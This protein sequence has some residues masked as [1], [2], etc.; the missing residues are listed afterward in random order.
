M[1]AVFQVGTSEQHSIEVLYSYWTGR[2]VVKVDG[3]VVLQK[4]IWFSDRV[5][6]E[7]GSLEKHQVELVCNTLTMTSQAYV[8]GRL[9]VGC[10]FPQVAGY[11]AMIL[12]VIGQLVAIVALRRP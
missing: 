1:I 3:I 11:H 4:Q 2:E 10:L 8:D 7:V 6:V 9:H 5:A 12:A